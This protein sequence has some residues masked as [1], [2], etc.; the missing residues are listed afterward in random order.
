MR[1]ELIVV[2]AWH[3]DVKVVIPG[4]E[5]VMAYGS[6]HR[7]SP[8]VIAQAMLPASSVDSLENGHNFQLKRTYIVCWHILFACKD[9]KN[10]IKSV[11]L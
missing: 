9:N 8:D 3:R 6:Y 4:D 10:K 1:D 7:T 5:S 2:G 11:T